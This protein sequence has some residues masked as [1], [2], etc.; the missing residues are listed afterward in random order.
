MPSSCH[1]PLLARMLCFGRHAPPKLTTHLRTPVSPRDAA[2]SRLP[3]LNAFELLFHVQTHRLWKS[4]PGRGLSR[5]EMYSYAKTIQVTKRPIYSCLDDEKLGST[6]LDDRV[7]PI[8]RRGSLCDVR[9]LQG[10]VV[11]AKPC[12]G[13]E[14][15]ERLLMKSWTFSLR[16]LYWICV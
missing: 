8:W 5:W 3:M 10:R 12:K 15:V 4:C 2:Q 7:D 13:T 1:Q 6:V 14:Y 11:R 9:A 16:T